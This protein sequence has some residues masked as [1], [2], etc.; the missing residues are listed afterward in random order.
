M[1]TP[2]MKEAWDKSS[3]RV[4]G[5]YSSQTP[6]SECASSCYEEG[7]KLE[8]EL[9]VVTQQRDKLT[10]ILGD[11]KTLAEITKQRDEA[12][13]Y[14]DR[15]LEEREQWRLSSVCRE[16]VE[17][18]DRLAD[19]LKQCREDSVELLGERDWWQ[20]ETRLDYQKRYRDTRDNIDRADDSLQSL[21][22]NEP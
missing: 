13:E 19:A 3:R 16:L 7:C 11:M 15:L 12:R 4:Y 8:R 20:N 17:Q 18:R 6:A 2:R 10:E 14:R 9:Q 21:T 5:F 22:T 1:N